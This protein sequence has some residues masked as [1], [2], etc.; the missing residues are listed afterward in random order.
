MSFLPQMGGCLW[1]HA[2][3]YAFSFGLWSSLLCPKPQPFEGILLIKVLGRRLKLSSPAIWLSVTSL[4]DDE[5]RRPA[6]RAHF[7]ISAVCFRPTI[8]THYD[9][10]YLYKLL[11]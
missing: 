9:L 1:Q 11:D 6:A 2:L 5:L 8:M 4:W 3:G 10:L 7:W